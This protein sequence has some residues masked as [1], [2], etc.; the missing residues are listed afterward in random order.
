MD[1][2]VAALLTDLEERGLLESTLVMWTGEFGRTPVMQGNR[3]R[4]HNPYGFS[5]W[6]AGGGV[7]GGKVIGATD[8]HGTPIAVTSRQP[9]RGGRAR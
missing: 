1:R 5:A 7:R 2:P 6:M 4:D 9:S 8:E 3:G